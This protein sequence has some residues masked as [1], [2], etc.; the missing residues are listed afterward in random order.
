MPGETTLRAMTCAMALQASP[1]K[2]AV[3]R[4]EWT[5]LPRRQQRA[6]CWEEGEQ[7]VRWARRTWP[8]LR[9]ELDRLFGFVAEGDPV[10]DAESIV[11]RALERRGD[12]EPPPLFGRLP[13][14]LGDPLGATGRR[15][16]IATRWSNRHRAKRSGALPIPVAGP[17]TEPVLDPGDPGTMEALDGRSGHAIGIPYDE[18]DGTLGAYRRGHV[19]VLELD[20]RT[21]SADPPPSPLPVPPM[22][23]SRTVRRGMASGD[24]DIDA[25]VRW[26]VD[27][28]AGGGEDPQL[29]T[30]LAPH[31]EPVAW[32]VLVDASA[33]SSLRGGNVLRRSVQFA[34]RLAQALDPVAVFAFCS[35]GRERVEMRVLKHFDRP[36]LPLGD[37]VKP[38]GY[39]RLGAAVRHAGARLLATPARAHVLVSLGDALPYDEG[40]GERYGTQDVAKAVE[41][42]RAAGARV[43]H[44]A[45]ATREDVALDVI[46][47]A[48][49][50]RHVR[51]DADLIALIDEV[52]REVR[53]G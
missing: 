19:R 25:V 52:E 33:S 7:A 2:E 15:T 14:P 27:L 31:R 51:R 26:R 11:G 22:R 35:H 47:G 13:P 20:Q 17:G 41:E 24:V 34:D 8:G 29:Y 10:L 42:Q 37:E 9:S 48:G 4:A 18:W 32:A 23:P 43:V 38:G 6:L 1:T 12:P 49:A 53:R 28:L 16:F 5:A 50:W 36:Y 44:A 45:L 46:F 40:Y 21:R 30:A 3:A 39:T